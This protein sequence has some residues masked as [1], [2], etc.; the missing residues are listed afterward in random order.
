MHDYTTLDLQTK[1]ELIAFLR[2]Y[3]SVHKF[4]LMDKV[5]AQRTRHVTV[6]MENLYDQHNIN[7][8]LRSCEAF[9]VQDVHVVD[10]DGR[11]LPNKHVTGGAARWLS[12]THYQ[13]GVHNIQSCF[14]HL[15]NGGYMIAATTLR[16]GGIPLEKLDISQKVALCFGT[17]EMGL[18][19][20]AHEFADV[21]VTLPMMGFTQSF[22]V[23][24]AVAL[25]LNI[26]MSRLHLTGVMWNLDEN[27]R[28]DLKI[29]WLLQI[30]YYGQN[31]L[32]HFLKTIT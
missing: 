29:K 16:E 31:L 9:G 11:F 2:P 21:F 17:E 32:R 24:V 26:L 25:C 22:N 8:S 30:P 27:E 6:V 23:S 7:A 3:V 12:I 19:D 28:I 14:T 20:E 15:K 10:D 4:D 18:S 1:R 13:E 5:L